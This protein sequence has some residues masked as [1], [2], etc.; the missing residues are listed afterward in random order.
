MDSTGRPVFPTKAE[1]AYPE[2]LCKR[3][4]Q[5]VRLRAIERGATVDPNALQPMGK[6]EEGRISR[7]HGLSALPPLVAEYRLVTDTPPHGEIPHK[8]VSTLP[9]SGKRGDDESLGIRGTQVQLSK[10][11]KAGN[12]LY[13]VYRIF[14]SSWRLR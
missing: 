6:Q 14:V 5:V 12:T 7:R 9:S 2:L 13:G 1:A 4:A 3:V 10:E 8:V 11:Y